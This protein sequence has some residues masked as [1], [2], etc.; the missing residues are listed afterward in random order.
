LKEKKATKSDLR[1]K[2]YEFAQEQIEV[3]KNQLKK[4][5]LFTNYDAFY[6]TS[7]KNY[8]AEQIKVFNELLKKNLIYRD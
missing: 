2:C 3:Q 1:K 5:G 8:E 6:V 7:D 4:L